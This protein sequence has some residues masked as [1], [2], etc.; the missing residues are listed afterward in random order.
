MFVYLYFVY[1]FPCMNVHYVHTGAWGG[2]N[3]V[4]HFLDLYLQAVVS[5]TDVDLGNLGFL[6]EQKVT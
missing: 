5:Q 6:Q 2:Q 3:K 4:T 1:V